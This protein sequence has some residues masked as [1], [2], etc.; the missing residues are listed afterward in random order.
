M[1]ATIPIPGMA[2]MTLA[3]GVALGDA[4]DLE[5]G[6]FIV[7]VATGIAQTD[8]PSEGWGDYYLASEDAI[9]SSEDQIARIDSGDWSLWFVLAA[10]SEDK[11]FCGVQFSF[12]EYEASIF[13]FS[14]FGFST[15]EDATKEFIKKYAPEGT[16]KIVDD[17][18]AWIETV[19]PKTLRDDLQAAAEQHMKLAFK[20]YE[21]LRKTF[22]T[23]NDAVEEFMEKYAPTN[24]KKLQKDIEAWLEKLK[25]K[26]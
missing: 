9:D 7:H 5:G 10:W 17:V 19:A 20:Q 21:H 22:G 8:E 15:P 14:S 13:G 23:P 12:E 1:L 18:N 16:Q 24:V 3:A 4:T 6:V 25:P 11:H 26:K 2:W